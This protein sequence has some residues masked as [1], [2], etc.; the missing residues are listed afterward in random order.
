MKHFSL[1][2]SRYI[3][4]VLLL[5]S[6]VPVAMAFPADTYT[7]R[8]VL[9]DGRWVKISVQETGMHFIP[10]ATLRSWGFTDPAKVR[11]YGSGGTRISDR[12]SLDE[13]VDDLPQVPALRT[14]S[15]I[16]FHARGPVSWTFTNNRY[17]HSRNPFSDVGYYFLTASDTPALEPVVEGTPNLTAEPVTTFTSTALH[18]RD[19]TNLVKEGHCFV[20]EDFRGTKN[21]T[22]DFTL[23]DMVADEPLSLR[24]A[25]ATISGSSTTLT[26]T[27]NDSPIGSPIMISGRGSNEG[28]RSVTLRSVNLAAPT[29]KLR[30]GVAFQSSGVVSAAN[31]D[32]ISLNYIR[33]IKLYKGQLA[34][35]SA[36]TSVLLSDADASTHVWDV[37]SPQKVVA[38]STVA[39]DGGVRWTNPYTGRR[40]YVA[41]NEKASMPVPKLVGNVANQNLH[42]LET[43]PD[44]VIITVRDF[45]GEADRLANLHRNG[46]DALDVV[47]VCQDDI[48]NEF[49]SGVRDPG[50]LRRYL[51][52]V[53]DRG[54]AAGHP[55]RYV[56]LFGGGYY[57]NRAIELSRSAAAQP[58]MPMWETEDNFSYTNSYTTDDIFA[59]LDDNSGLNITSD[60]ISVALGRIPARSLTSAKSY[61]DKLYS[62]VQKP[63]MSDWKNRFMTMADNGNDGVFLTDCENFQRSLLGNPDGSEMSLTKVYID[64]FPLENG[65]CTAGRARFH[66]MLDDGVVWLSYVGHGSVNYV[67][68]ENVLSAT[69]ISN[70][71]N[72]IW[73]FMVSATCSFQHWD[74]E[75]ASG[76]EVMSF[77]E[78]AGIIASIGPTRKV[79][80]S[81]NSRIIDAVGKVALK[82]DSLGRFPTIGEINR[83]YKNELLTGGAALARLRYTL[84]GDPAMRLAIPSN[85]VVLESIN[86][87]ELTPDAQTTVMARQ[88]VTLKGYVADP[89]GDK[90]SDFNGDLLYTLHD[91]EYST[92]SLGADADG[93][94]GKE[95]TFEEQGD[96]LHQGRAKVVAG[97]FTATFAMP[98]EVS[99][100]FRPAAMNLYA[101]NDAGVDASGLNRNF[102]VYGFDEDA[103]SDSLPPVIEYAYLNH[104]SFQQGGVVN[105]APMFMAR[106]S[107]DTGI[108]LS[109]AGIG[110]Q[111]SLKVDDRKSYTD[112]SLYYTPAPDG[113]P[114]G[115]IAYP[116]N[117]MTEGNH[118]IMFRVW[119]TSGNSTTHQLNFFVERGAAPKVF[120]VYTDA[121]PASTHANFYVSHN[122]PDATMT[123]TLDIYNM[124][125]R[126]VWTSTVTDRSDMFLSAPITWNLCDQGG[127]RVVRGIYIYRATVKVDGHEVAGEAKR[128]A[129]TGI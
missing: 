112:L 31:L 42:G 67:A 89:R 128:I 84:I 111:M 25:F 101:W 114:A 45:A 12:L 57:D 77:A 46:D 105:E 56:L 39:A 52:M 58:R 4:I 126:R 65:T 129:V 78:N 18:E 102:Y 80:I 6:A 61:V 81:D 33:C 83:D 116:M 8:S 23:P 79:N 55:L 85:R 104:E 103:A 121:N 7:G 36:K 30:I 28:T 21:R 29:E 108:N 106:V 118:T 88:N 27:A 49:G 34:F 32:F 94:S 51:K 98:S 113:S 76:A 41:W 123:V 100:N 91:A 71:S 127:Q 17:F 64:A 10:V 97:E 16:Y 68:N 74:S 50:A 40:D 86:G 11:V 26:L 122:R 47:V 69:D 117:E 59:M 66:R 53:Y 115:T 110:H 70:L 14:S 38:M 90:L 37:T 95:I 15:G 60:R 73:P 63:Q 96:K 82:R 1:L 72:R 93:T 2:F 35:Q 109:Q 125:G 124:L 99:D 44:M 19:L 120:D 119:D 13:F 43:T 3:F 87:S 107:D 75:A 54:N 92:T 48:F 9:A 24:V 22:F 5:L 20:G 62:Y